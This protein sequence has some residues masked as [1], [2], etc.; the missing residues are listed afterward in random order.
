MGLIP[1]HWPA[2]AAPGHPRH[3]RDH[4]AM[5]GHEASGA[6]AV[7]DAVPQ[8]KGAEQDLKKND[9]P[10]AGQK[11][12]NAITKLEEALKELEKK[13]EQ[14][15]EKEKKKQ[16]AG[17]EERLLKMLAKER[18]ILESTQRI[19][20]VIVR[21][22]GQAADAD[23]QKQLHAHAP[24]GR[25]AAIGAGSDR[26]RH[27]PPGGDPA[28]ARPGRAGSG[29]RPLHRRPA[30][31]GAGA[32]RRWALGDGRDRRRTGRIQNAGLPR[33]HARHPHRGARADDRRG[34]SDLE[35][36]GRRFRRCARSGSGC[37]LLVRDGFRR[38][39]GQPVA[40]NARK[41][42]AEPWR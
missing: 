29:A 24:P 7:Q 9:R 8:Q 12:D 10:N 31:R 17:L 34:G 27:D 6:R 25:A 26:H 42:P 28:R 2:E 36:G 19:N 30:G 41:R 11:E 38:D 20:D 3:H 35:D 21:N 23:R 37:A 1:A 18:E 15:R 14:L 4:V 40:R 32:G 22:K 13:L 33:A 16:L 39:H 5:R